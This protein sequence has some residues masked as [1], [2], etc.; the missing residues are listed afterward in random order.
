MDVPWGL[1]SFYGSIL[2]LQGGVRV[3]WWR[4]PESGQPSHCGC[5]PGGRGPGSPFACRFGSHTGGQ[6]HFSPGFQAGRFWSGRRQQAVHWS[7][8]DPPHPP[9][10]SS[11]R[12][13]GGIQSLGKHFWVPGPVHSRLCS[14]TFVCLLLYW[15]VHFLRQAL[16]SSSSSLVVVVV[17]F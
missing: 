2:F 17:V 9:C 14:Y 5:C 3:L 12:P 10:A 6:P 1:P 16:G 11:R 8:G 15:P 7:A 13:Q 4:N